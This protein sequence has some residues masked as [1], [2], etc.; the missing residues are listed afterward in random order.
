[1][2]AATFT[3]F[4]SYTFDQLALTAVHQVSGSQPLLGPSAVAGR[5]ADD[6]ASNWGEPNIGP[7][8]V[9][10]CADFLPVVYAPGNLALSGGR[11]QGVL[12][13]RGDLE[14]TGGVVLTGVV[15]V[16]G[17]VTTSGAGGQIVGTLLVAANTGATR[18]GPGTT[19]EYSS[20]AVGR[21]LG[22]NGLRATRVVRGWA[23]LY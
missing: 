11:G 10:E 20:C 7:G 16:L 22:A 2:T 13:V 21:A 8:T 12:L 1:M 5:C 15:V 9:P 18:L 19:V 14:L 6:V 17:R 3:R 23:E 4:G